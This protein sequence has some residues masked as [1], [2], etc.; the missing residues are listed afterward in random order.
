[1]LSP[2]IHTHSISSADVPTGRGAGCVPPFK[3]SGL[4]SFGFSVFKIFD[5][6]TLPFPSE[7]LLPDVHQFTLSV[8]SFTPS[9]AT[10]NNC[11]Y[12]TH[13]LLKEKCDTNN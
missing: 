5:Y 1:M 8:G 4:C 2:G 13:G 10:Y 11:L 6:E 9:L 12:F 7:C 3:I